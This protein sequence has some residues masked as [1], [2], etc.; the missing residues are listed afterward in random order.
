MDIHLRPFNGSDEDAEMFA[1]ALDTAGHGLFRLMIGRRWQQVLAAGGR[2]PGHDLSLEHVRFAVLGGNVVGVLSGMAARRMRETPPSVILRMA[3]WR[4]LRIG[5]VYLGGWPVFRAMA[6]HA[7]DEWYVLAI[8]VRPEQRG[9]GVGAAMLAA[10]EQ[11]ARSEGC[12][13]ITLDVEHANHGGIRLYERLGYRRQW[14]SAPALTGARI[15][16]MRKPL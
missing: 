13:A 6:E 16:R 8:A 4:A 15:H 9:S 2:L 11:Q 3:G 12:A 14:T 1:W 7:P 5:L 10:A